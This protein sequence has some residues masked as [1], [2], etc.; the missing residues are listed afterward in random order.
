MCSW[1]GSLIPPLSDLRSSS[2]P[3]PLC[4]TLQGPHPHPQDRRGPSFDSGPRHDRYGRLQRSR[5]RVQDRGAPYGHG[6]QGWE[7]DWQVCGSEK[8]GGSEGVPGVSVGVIGGKAA[9]ADLRPWG[10][11]YRA[12]SRG[13]RPTRACRIPDGDDLQGCPV[14]RLSLAPC[15]PSLLRTGYCFP[16][17]VTTYDYCS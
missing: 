6:I 15:L 5:R 9:R 16:L 4:R 13:L 3:S 12:R 8:R 1:C 10:L 17:R 2:P 7:A 14:L 11:L